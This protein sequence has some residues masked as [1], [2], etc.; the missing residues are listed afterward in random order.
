[1]IAG[2]IHTA[3]DS[4]NNWDKASALGLVLLVATLILYYV[5]NRLICIDK[6]KLG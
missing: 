5:Y 1:M 2:F 6:L 4:E 3:M